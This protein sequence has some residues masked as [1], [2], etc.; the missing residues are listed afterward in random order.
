M[1]IFFDLDGTLIDSRTRLYDLFIELSKIDIT[2]D[3]Y[4]FLKRQMI[5]NQDILIKN[6][7]SQEQVSYF[8][9]KWME[10]IELPHYL[11]KD[12][13]FDFTTQVLQ[14]LKK[15]GYKM[16]VITAR[17]SIEEANNQL[18]DLGIF[19]Y[20]DDFLVTEQRFEKCDL[21]K[22]YKV[23][24]TSNDFM[25]GDTGVDIKAGKTLGMKTVAVLTGFRSKE[26]LVSYCP[27]YIYKD[28]L[29]FS[30]NI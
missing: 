12:R 26:N 2:F 15:K 16:F 14:A 18:K 22:N 21:I 20:F 3:E 1:N 6:L 11:G 27:D 19:E 5:S 23:K 8:T 28:I 7:F 24:I 4:W 9:D 13:K 10:K 25:V 29:E 30:Q 17:Q